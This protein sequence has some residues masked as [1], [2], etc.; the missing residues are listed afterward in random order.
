MGG[1]SSSSKT[2][3][4][5]YDND[6]V[7]SDGGVVMGEGGSYADMTDNDGTILA[8]GEGAS[9]INNSLDDN[10]TALLSEAQNLVYGNTE[11]ILEIY[12]NLSGATDEDPE[13]LNADETAFPADFEAASEETKSE[14]LKWFVG[15]VVV[16]AAVALAAKWKGK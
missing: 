10:T 8:L 6:M 5:T 2:E 12:A 14:N 15:G 3:Y 16:I 11:N 7:A 4:T 1:G 9:Y 13:F